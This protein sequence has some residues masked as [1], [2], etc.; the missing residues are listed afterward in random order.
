M[1][2]NLN[3]GKNLDTRLVNSQEGWDNLFQICLLFNNGHRTPLS[4]NYCSNY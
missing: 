3:A 1:H 2:L 4:Y